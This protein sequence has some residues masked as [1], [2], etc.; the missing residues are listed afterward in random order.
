MIE[1]KGLPPKPSMILLDIWI[2]IRS[3]YLD[4]STETDQ[5]FATPPQCLSLIHI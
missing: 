4:L 3:K 1:Q 2:T 5:S